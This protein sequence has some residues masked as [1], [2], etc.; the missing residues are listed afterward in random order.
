MAQT[1]ESVKDIISSPAGS[2]MIPSILMNRYHEIMGE[3]RIF[4]Y[5][6][7]DPTYGQCVLFFNRKHFTNRAFISKRLT[8]KMLRNKNASGH[9]HILGIAFQHRYAESL[10]ETSIRKDVIC[11]GQ[12]FIFIIN[13]GTS[14]R[15]D[16]TGYFYFFRHL[17]CQS[18]CHHIE[19]SIVITDLSIITCGFACTKI[20]HLTTYECQAFRLRI[21]F[22]IA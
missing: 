21:A 20:S 15:K 1:K 19:N 17:F 12:Q 10:K 7:V 14:H 11:I 2:C 4:R 22:L 5:I 13:I 8:G 3:H 6:F 9:N 18:R 16:T